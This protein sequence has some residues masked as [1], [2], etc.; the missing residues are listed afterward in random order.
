M[1]IFSSATNLM[2]NLESAANDN[3]NFE[4]ATLALAIICLASGMML[5]SF[6][7]TLGSIG[8]LPIN[9][10]LLLFTAGSGIAVGVMT[11]VSASTPLSISQHV[12][13]AQTAL[14]SLNQKNLDTLNNISQVSNDYN[15]LANYLSTN[16]IYGISSTTD[17][18]QTYSQFLQNLINLYGTSITSISGT[19]N[20]STIPFTTPDFSSLISAIQNQ[21]NYTTT[22]S[23][24]S[25]KISNAITDNNIIISNS[26][27]GS[28]TYMKCLLL[29]QLFNNLTVVNQELF[30]N[31]QLDLS[32][33]LDEVFKAESTVTAE[34]AEIYGSSGTIQQQ[35]LQF[36][37]DVIS[38]SLI[39][40]LNPS[41]SFFDPVALFTQGFSNFTP[42]VNTLLSSYANLAIS[43]LPANL[44]FSYK[45]NSSTILQDLALFYNNQLLVSQLILLA[46]QITTENISTPTTNSTLSSFVSQLAAT[47][48]NLTNLL[49]IYNSTNAIYSLSHQSAGNSTILS[50]VQ[51]VPTDLTALQKVLALTQFTDNTQFYSSTC[52]AFGF[53]PLLV[54]ALIKAGNLDNQTA[55]DFMNNYQTSTSPFNFFDLT[56]YETFISSV[57][58]QQNIKKAGINNLVTFSDNVLSFLNQ[59]QTFFSN[60]TT[61]NST[62]PYSNL[63]ASQNWQ[64]L[65]QT[66]NPSV[67]LA[68]QNITSTVLQKYLSVWYAYSWINN[69]GFSNNMTSVSSAM[70]WIQTNLTNLNSSTTWSPSLWN[71]GLSTQNPLN[72]II[73]SQDFSN[74]VQ[75][76]GTDLN[77][78]I[79]K[80]F[81]NTF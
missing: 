25:T 78:L 68:V 52:K 14:N 67:D 18:V 60:L 10:V 38:N 33:N 27:S 58:S 74:T 49:N 45:Q 43:Q 53:W 23:A 48:V 66:L 36:Y 73:F 65:I 8:K 51:Q 77:S 57:S 35:I 40:S 7:N 63:L 30:K 50:Q 6:G 31:S 4:I 3:K 79:D 5:S 29:A 44:Q 34:L 32:S 12:P 59:L 61:I 55:A 16:A 56:P 9:N 62:N 64:Q 17:P 81:A 75:Q 28:S 72:R 22:S 26:M 69:L 70:K 41:D 37:T 13:E 71:C 2:T 76:S 21:M 80:M 54:Q 46:Q 15:T 1:V 47:S 24:S 42:D 11:V 39:W 20:S 19:I